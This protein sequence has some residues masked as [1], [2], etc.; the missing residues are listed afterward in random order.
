MP[1][2]APA[3]RPR[4]LG[5]GRHE[6]LAGGQHVEGEERRLLRQEQSRHP[7]D[8]E[9]ADAHRVAQGGRPPGGVTRGGPQPLGHHGDAH[10]DVAER[11]G[12]EAA[13]VER[14]VHA[15]GEDQDADDLDEGQEAVQEVVDVVGRREPG[16]ID[17]CPPDGEEDHE[18]A[19]DA[20]MEVAHR[21][22]DVE[23]IGRLGDRHDEAEVEEQLEWR[24]RPVLLLNVPRGP[25]SARTRRDP[26]VPEL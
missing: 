15:G 8:L 24:R 20:R 9:D 12:R 3:T 5:P 16:E 14:A 22:G 25:V 2:R 11:D 7:P 21:E 23:L 19:D 4:P 6:H 18:V 13:T 10:D 1:G 26:L 17:P